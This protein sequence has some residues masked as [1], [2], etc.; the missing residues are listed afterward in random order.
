MQLELEVAARQLVVADID[1]RLRPVSPKGAKDPLML[2]TLARLPAWNKR[3]AAATASTI[4]LIFRNF[5]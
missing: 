1:F 2:L 4:F 5:S 3:S